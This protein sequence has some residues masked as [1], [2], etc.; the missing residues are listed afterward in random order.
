MKVPYRR[1]EVFSRRA[2][3]LALNGITKAAIRNNGLIY[4]K[5]QY[6]LTFLP[7]DREYES[8]IVSL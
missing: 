6:L 2:A 7:R 4:L 1:R 5:S 8:S 3:V